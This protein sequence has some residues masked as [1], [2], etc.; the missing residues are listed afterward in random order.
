MRKFSSD[1]DGD[2]VE[3][4][5]QSLVAQEEYDTED[6]LA[7]MA[8]LYSQDINYEIL[9]VKSKPVADEC[10]GVDPIAKAANRG[11]TGVSDVTSG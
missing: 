11:N 6:I 7:L 8:N 4:K 2:E 3:E 9:L 10:A 5:I 1:D